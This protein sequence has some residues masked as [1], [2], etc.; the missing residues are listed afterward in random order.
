MIW[1]SLLFAYSFPLFPS[2]YELKILPCALHKAM[3]PSE[4]G[5]NIQLYAAWWESLQSVYDLTAVSVRKLIEN[6]TQKNEGKLPLK[7]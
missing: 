1:F 5:K 2:C 7:V 6:E 4:N 3:C